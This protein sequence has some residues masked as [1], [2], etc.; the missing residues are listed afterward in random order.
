MDV[1]VLTSGEALQNLL[2]IAG[3]NTTKV[4]NSVTLVVISDRIRKMADKRGFSR[5]LVT[6]EPGDTAIVKTIKALLNG[7]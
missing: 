2:D 7:E 3:E 1:I 6:E 4:L 5:I